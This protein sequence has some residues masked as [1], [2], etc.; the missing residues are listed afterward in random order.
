MFTLKSEINPNVSPNV[1]VYTPND[2]ELFLS[3][4]QS[5]VFFQV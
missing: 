5:F 3:P 1:D 2:K 4:E